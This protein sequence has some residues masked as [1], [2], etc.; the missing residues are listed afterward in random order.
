MTDEILK[1][2]GPL[3]G[4]AGNW[5]GTKGADTAPGKQREVMRTPFTERMAFVPFGPVDNHEQ[6]LWGLRYNTTVTRMLDGAGFHEDLGYWLW[7]P[8]ARQVYRC[9]VIPRGVTV[10]AGGAVDADARSFKLVAEVGSPTFGICSNPFLDVEF[11]T[12]RYEL[13]VDIHNADSFSYE[14]DTQLLMKG[15]GE[16]FHHVD[17]NTLSRVSS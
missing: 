15:R 10:M 6:Q 14:A 9:F 7:D 17:K 2:L 3:A 13:T 11:R 8:R 16:I 1:N 12:V 4:L 5:E